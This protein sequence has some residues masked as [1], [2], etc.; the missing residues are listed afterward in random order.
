LRST[1]LEFYLA[2]AAEAR[3]EAESATL[4]HVRERSRRCEAAWT[5]LAQRAERSQ[6]FRE[7]EHNRKT[8]ETA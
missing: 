3:A 4:D 5:E 1:T 8:N 6:Q 2:R 7:D